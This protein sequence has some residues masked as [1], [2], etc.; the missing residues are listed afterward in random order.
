MRRKNRWIGTIIAIIILAGLIGF[1][2]DGHPSK[3]SQPTIQL[4]LHQQDKVIAMELEEY[5][6]GTVAAEMPVAFEIEAL[7]AQAV[8]ARTYAIKKIIS[9]TPY[10]DGADLSDD[11]AVCQAFVSL[12]DFAPANPDRTELLDKIKEA[13]ESTRGEILLY[14]SQPIDALYC[15]TCGGRTESASAVWGGR[16]SYLQSVKC[17]DCI[18]SQHYKDE[19][20]IANST[21][22]GLVAGIDGPLRI[23]VISRSPG[24][25]AQKID[26]NGKVIEA[27]AL[28]Q[29]LG[30]PSTWIEFSTL[31][32]TTTITSRGYGHG[33][34]MCQFG[35]NGMAKRGKNY[36]QILQ[37]YYQGVTFYNL[38]Y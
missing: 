29:R 28:R 2:F 20:E 23:K 6:V 7:K 3:A 12:L 11:I 13:V 8:C 17:N 34:G 5:I 15:S 10:P 24:G 19:I 37:K 32:K 14:D 31:A 1:Y 36:R 27:T 9:N 30:L 4:Y 22:L 26:I 35:A 33:V 38:G 16:I 21:I 25:R 18:Q